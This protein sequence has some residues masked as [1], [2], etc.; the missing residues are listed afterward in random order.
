MADT[1]VFKNA[2]YKRSMVLDDFTVRDFSGGLNVVDNDLNLSSKFSVVLQNMQREIDGSIGIRP[3]TRLFADMGSFISSVVNIEYYN[4]FI[5]AVGSAGNVVKVDSSGT[6]TEIW[7]ADFASKLPGAPLGWR[8]T[9]FASFAIFNGQ[10]IICNGVNKPLLVNKAMATTYLN[11]PATGSNANTPICKYVRT[12]DRYLLMSG[13][14]TNVDRLH[15]SHQDSSGVWVG[16]PAPNTAVW[17]DLGS[18]V[19]SGSE[20][21]RGIGRFRDNVIVAFDEALLP[22]KLGAYTGGI[23][24]PAFSD[25]IESNGSISHRVI[26]SLGDDMVF[27]DASGV[28]TV[29]R[30]LFTGNVKPA[31]LSDLIDPAI[32]KQI[33][34]VGTVAGLEDH[35]FSVLDTLAHNYMLFIPNHEL[36]AARTETRCFA[37]KSIKKLKVE[38]WSEFIDWNWTCGCRSSLKKVFFGRDSM[39]YVM[40]DVNDPITSD[41]QGDQ[42]CWD[43]D[44]CF[45][46][47][48]GW[49]PAADD[50]GIPIR[51]RWELPWA[52]EK[53]RFHE[54]HSRYINFDT[55]GTATFTA[56]MFVDNIYEL[57][58]DPGESWLDDTLFDDNLGWEY[59][60]KPLNPTLS[61][62]FVGG[63]R[64]GYGGA[65][66]GSLYGGGRSTTD[67]RLYAWPARYKLHKNRIEGEALGA[68]KIV[69]L[70]MA[71][72]K[73]SPQR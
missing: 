46:D 59:V 55:V 15:I 35:C 73:G 44:T 11:D 25:A 51:F 27:C 38:A 33:G 21:V 67:E 1:F 62:Q 20:T 19:P 66:F 17:I 22:G 36:P 65:G 69:S 41:Y 72:M 4:G 63:S 16:D 37:Y 2:Q 10:L 9:T 26:Q 7:N 13:D 58:T 54:K 68:L 24:I 64:K 57:D 12:H 71:Y 47:Q 5:V 3:G 8:P 30:A 45:T 40:G 29:E 49:Y 70:T 42:E 32:Q 50:K 39:I 23:H 34:L 56:M 18:R 60:D 52:D 53:D 14:P 48:Y 28:P 6:V 31:R 43:D 61:M